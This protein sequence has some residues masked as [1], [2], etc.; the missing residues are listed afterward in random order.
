MTHKITQVFCLKSKEYFEISEEHFSDLSKSLL[1]LS[2]YSPLIINI[3]SNFE[4]LTQV[5]K[6]FEKNT[7]FILHNINFQKNNE[8]DSLYRVF[9]DL[10]LINLNFLNYPYKF[11]LKKL[12]IR[13]V[14]LKRI[15][16]SF[17][18]KDES[19][20]NEER[21]PISKIMIENF[22]FK[23][24]ED[25]KEYYLKHKKGMKQKYFYDDNQIEELSNNYKNFLLEQNLLNTFNFSKDNNFEKMYLEKNNKKNVKIPKIVFTQIDKE[26]TILNSFKSAE[27]C[28]NLTNFYI[29]LF[30]SLLTCLDNYIDDIS[31]EGEVFKEKY[32]DLNKQEIKKYYQNLLAYEEKI[33][34]IL[35]EINKKNVLIE[36]LMPGIDN[37]KDVI[38]ICRILLMP[39]QFF[40]NY[41]EA[42]FIAA[43][44]G[45]SGK[46]KEMKLK[47]LKQVTVIEMIKKTIK[48]LIDDNR[49]MNL[50]EINYSLFIMT[51]VQY[52]A[53]QGFCLTAWYSM[54]I[55]IPLQEFENIYPFL[56]IMFLMIVIPLG[57]LFIFYKFKNKII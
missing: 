14:F 46:L 10:L 35:E 15:I 27:I 7:E 52:C 56:F 23:L 30:T 28:F 26:Q 33:Y 5:L 22:A 17:I 51:V 11:D 18:C 2:I 41:S 57:Q 39:N 42:K 36:N 50:K 8:I 53:L 55:K 3:N 24:I 1:L 19:Y 6:L 37:N 31:S 9:K 21:D 20:K 47:V 29:I 43:I 44:Q 48:I 12:S 45:F 16:I 34:G 4:I 13:I 49:Y 32:L 40:T 54:N 25:V 38:K